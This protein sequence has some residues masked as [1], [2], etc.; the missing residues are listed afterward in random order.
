MHGLAPI[1]SQIRFKASML[2]IVSTPIG[3]LEDITF[4]A[5]NTLKESDFI[6]CEDTRVSRVLLNHYQIS[7]ELISVN[8]FN[9]SRKIEEI[10]RR[11][12]RG[13]I[14]SLISDAGT[15]LISDPGTRL[16]SAARKAGIQ[17][18]P[19]PGPS[20]LTAALSTAGFAIDE[21]HYIGFLPQ[22]KGRQKTLSE[23]REMECAVVMFESVYRIKK[24]LQE[25]NAVM[26][27]R[28]VL[29][30]REM[31]KKFEEILEGTPAQLMERFAENEPKGEFVVILAPKNWKHEL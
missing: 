26:P 2:F 17:I 8:A 27:D 14:A 21:F 30:C 15:P 19:V 5:V 20:S 16:L 25:L 9:E 4:R 13:E 18:V 7:K 22:K 23:L 6:L 29:V 24:L 1:G 10:I 31:T 3:N 11:L 28:L 12:E